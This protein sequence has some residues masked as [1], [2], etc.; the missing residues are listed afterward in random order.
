MYSGA[1]Q[2]SAGVVGLFPEREVQDRLFLGFPATANLSHGI[3]G[4]T[5]ARRCFWH[6]GEK[7]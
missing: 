3:A 7:K 2:E 6:S 4:A 1:E 5:N